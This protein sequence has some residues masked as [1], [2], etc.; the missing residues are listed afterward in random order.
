MVRVKWKT[1]KTLDRLLNEHWGG[2]MKARMGPWKRML[3]LGGG[4]GSIS[5]NFADAGHSVVSMDLS[6]EKVLK[7]RGL[8]KDV[9]N[10]NYV[11]G[12]AHNLPFKDGAFDVVHS[13]AALHHFP[14]K[15]KS[16]GEVRRVLRPG[17]RLVALEPGLV[18]PFAAPARKFFP[19]A[20]HDRMEKPFVPSSLKKT[21]SEFF[22]KVETR[23]FGF[24]VY[25]LPFI[26]ARLGKIS[27]LFRPIEPHL[28]KLDDGVSKMFRDFA[29][30]IAIS[31][32]KTT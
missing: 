4:I 18:N 1:E 16:L 17:G 19:T 7:G 31:A 32:E 2:W 24:L 14:D 12:D 22:G 6:R 11:V 20:A 25:I 3:D 30:V 5:V 10:M 29:G 13:W 27:S 26:L 21:M 9:P 23:S 28:I 15:R 8:Y